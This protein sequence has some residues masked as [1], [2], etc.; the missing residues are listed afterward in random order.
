M[1]QAVRNQGGFPYGELVAV[2]GVNDRVERG[3]A[4]AFVAVG[5]PV[6]LAEDLGGGIEKPVGGSCTEEGENLFADFCG[7]VVGEYISFGGVSA[8]AP[9]VDGENLFG[10]AVVDRGEADFDGWSIAR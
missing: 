5:L 3:S 4:V 8:M 9:D 1:D 6:D 10:M 7:Q 2:G